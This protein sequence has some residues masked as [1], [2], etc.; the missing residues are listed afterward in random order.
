M[1]ATSLCYIMY[2]SGSTGKPKGT[3]TTHTNVV[4]VV[5][6]TNYIDITTDD[7][8][9]QLSNYAFDGSVFDIYGALLNGAALVLPERGQALSADRLAA[10]IFGEMISVFFV[11]TA[12][13]NV[14]VD[15][16]VEGFQHVRKVLFGGERVSVAHVRKAFQFMGKGRIL[17]VYGPT[18]TTVYA[19]YYVVEDLEEQMGTIPIGK[20]IANTTVYIMDSRMNPVPIGVTGEVFIGGDGVSRGYLNNPELTEANFYRS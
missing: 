9:L 14:L 10:F 4:R 6:N 20:P 1:T 19:T 18:E 15:V 16:A 8:L 12:L 17:H 2:T 3:L 7:R 13:F 5:R 11:T